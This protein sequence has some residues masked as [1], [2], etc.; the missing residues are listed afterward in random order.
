MQKKCRNLAMRKPWYRAATNS[1]YL[2]TTGGKQ[3][4][5]GKDERYSSAPKVRPKEPPPVIQKKYLA[6]MQSEAEPEDRQLSFCVEQYVDSLRDCV[7][8]SIRRSKHYLDLFLAEV[9]DIKISRLKAHHL[10]EF[11]RGKAWSPNTVRQVIITVNACL[12]HCERQDWIG[13]NPIKGKVPMPKAHRREDIMGGEDSE[14]VIAAA[15]VPFKTVLKF[16]AGTGVRPI[17]AR[18]ARVEKCDLE[19]GI[20]MVPNKTRKQ[21]GNQER[22][23]F[24]STAMID[25]CREVIGGRK[26][27]WLFLNRDGQP[28]KGDTLRKRMERLCEQLGI[29]KGARLYSSRHNFASNAINE[30]GMH[31]ALLAVQLGH[32][33]TKM[34][35]KHYLHSDHEA[36]RKALDSE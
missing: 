33:D 21:T 31:V 3:I 17:E 29:E 19:K 2:E 32:V 15:P 16:L 27:G 36:M 8:N 25:L 30:K 1:W 9:G 12:N 11:L 26:E 23:V 22:P 34:L 10:S 20:V 14:A 7:Q 24:L 18:E 35:L 6:A 4:N 13:R 28:W 5:L